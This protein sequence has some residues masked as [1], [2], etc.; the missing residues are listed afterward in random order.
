MV[1]PLSARVASLALTALLAL[2]CS[3][4]RPSE[5]VTTAANDAFD[6]R[7]FANVPGES[8]WIF[9]L[10]EPGGEGH[11][12]AK[13]H[14]GWI[15][16]SEE[17]GHDPKVTTGQDY[18]WASS[19]GYGVIVRLNNGYENSPSPG[20]LP[21]EQD[22]G[23]FA[24]RAASFVAA[25]KGAHIW[26]IGNETNMGREWPSCGVTVCNDTDDKGNLKY[27]NKE[28]ITA[29]RYAKA[30][31]LVRAAI[32]GV[33]GHDHDQVVVQ[34]T[35]PVN[36]E[37][38]CAP[39]T[40][41]SYDWVSYHADILN[42]LYSSWAVA[43]DGFAIHAYTHGSEP[44]LIT[45]GYLADSANGAPQRHYHFQSY[46]DFLNATPSFARTLPVYVTE[47]DQ[48]RAPSWD[49]A[50]K[51]HWIQDAYAEI[52]LWNSDASHQ[53]IRALAIYRWQPGDAKYDISTHPNV[54]A[55]FD[56]AVGADYRWDHADCDYIQETKQRTCDGPNGSFRAT[57]YHFGVAA[58]GFPL[59]PEHCVGDECYQT[60]ERLRMNRSAQSPCPYGACL[61]FS[62]IDALK[63]D[64]HQDI[65]QGF[66]S[67]ADLAAAGCK[68]GS[69]CS[70]C[71]DAA[72]RRR[73]Q[74]C[75]KAFGGLP[76][77]ATPGQ[78][79]LIY[80]LNHGLE[81]YGYPITRVLPACAWEGGGTR[82]CFYTERAKLG[83]FGDD[84]D[85][86]GNP[87]KGTIYEWQGMRLGAQEL[88]VP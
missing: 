14:P 83:Y 25:S 66:I 34:G 13:Q 42:Q 72:Y 81:L 51:S 10:H 65:D 3:T 39:G 61:S 6:A 46:R 11:M 31:K 29:A 45:S 43:A 84:K 87:L 82:P 19:Q 88:G 54:V 63:R 8:P 21:C 71:D 70:R 48:E 27:P 36:N 57:F 2:G 41:S 1:Q 58:V 32:K 69:P 20:T 85:Q 53:R 68:P 33:Q 64:V 77:G 76:A 80:D 60:F 49:D 40:P 28:P 59:E 79:G 4:T 52:N 44:A 37:V 17:I 35:A 73:T 9:G 24:T 22:Y 5:E 23:D 86:N 55:D 56:A 74:A 12:M 50:P 38:A 78:L 16:F 47:S 75:V 62:G 26:V 7:S 18:S 30:F 67:D 15:V